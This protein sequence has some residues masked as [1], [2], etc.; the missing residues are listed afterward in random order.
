[1]FG[2]QRQPETVTAT[3]KS[4]TT[5]EF[6]V[7]P[8]NTSFNPVAAVYMVLKTHSS[9]YTILYVGE[10][11][12]LK[13]R[14]DNHHKQPCFD[15]NGKSHIGVLREDGESRRLRIEADLVAGYN[16]TCNG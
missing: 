8:W 1:M 7:F 6:Q 14:F 5:Y 10:T 11:D 9:Q 16:P 4:G 15:R 12:N 3:G 13:E 2:A